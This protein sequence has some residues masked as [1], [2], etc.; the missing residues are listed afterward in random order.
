MAALT[1]RFTATAPRLQPALLR[2]SV[3]SSQYFSA[4]RGLPLKDRKSIKFEDLRCG[5][6]FCRVLPTRQFRRHQVLA[7]SRL[8]D[9]QDSSL[10]LRIDEKLSRDELR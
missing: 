7:K 3:I 9:N 5:R 4:R 1:P 2:L 8:A 6:V 10:N